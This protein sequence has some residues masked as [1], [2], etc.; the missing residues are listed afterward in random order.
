MI[1]ASDSAQTAFFKFLQ[2][3]VH[4]SCKKKKANLARGLSICL[5]PGHEI[6]F[7]L[8]LSALEGIFLKSLLSTA[9]DE[10]INLRH[11]IVALN[12]ISSVNLFSIEA[13]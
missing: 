1:I 4:I 7:S 11:I 3:S 8:T 12:C 5:F 13:V 6:Y 10:T 2:K 9:K